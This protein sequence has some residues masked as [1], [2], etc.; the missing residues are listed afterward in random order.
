VR[1]CR[2]DGMKVLSLAVP[3]FRRLAKRPRGVLEVWVATLAVEAHQRCVEGR[4]RVS[5]ERRCLVQ[6]TRLHVVPLNPFPVVIA[7]GEKALRRSVSAL[8][9]FFFRGTS[10]FRHRPLNV[11]LYPFFAN[12]VKLTEPMPRLD[13][14]LSGRLFVPFRRQNEVLRH[15]VTV[16]EGLFA[17]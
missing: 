17:I 8:F 16:Y 2:H 11:P 5:S 9:A 3:V 12:I 6:C 14:S 13:A 15:P 1:Y 10:E 7:E 4:L